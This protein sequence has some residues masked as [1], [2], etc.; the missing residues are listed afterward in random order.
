MGFI[1]VIP[2][3]TMKDKTQ[4]GK[5]VWSPSALPTEENDN[6]REDHYFDTSCQKCGHVPQG[7]R[8]LCNWETP[9]EHAQS[10][11]A[12]QGD[13]CVCEPLPDELFETPKE[14]WRDT[15]SDLLVFD[16]G[17][18][19]FDASGERLRDLLLTQRQEILSRQDLT[20]PYL[21]GFKEG[22]E[23]ARQEIL[24]M[25]EG[26]PEYTK[27]ANDEIAYI[28]KADLSHRIEERYKSE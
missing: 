23:E 20:T 3:P 14:N 6:V 21:V 7:E 11:P 16:L 28:R 26:M 9:K 27:F 1:Q 17:D 2:P 25:I 5:G 4:P 8:H 22:K 12:Q 10:C 15:F 13:E 19:D 18:I 24:S